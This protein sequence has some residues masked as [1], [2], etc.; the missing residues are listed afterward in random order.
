MGIS[1]DGILFFGF[2]I[3]EEVPWIEDDCEDYE[4]WI[5]WKLGCNED[6][7]FDE[8][9]SFF[10]EAGCRIGLHCSYDYPMYYV[11]LIDK[12]IYSS[13][14]YPERITD[15]FLTVDPEDIEKLKTFCKTLGIEWQEPCWFL[16]SMYG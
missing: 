8:R 14:G 1:S 4:D 16:A 7:D 3:G 2:D 12:N 10:K 13:R 15:E 9:G 11:Y 5:L 6:A